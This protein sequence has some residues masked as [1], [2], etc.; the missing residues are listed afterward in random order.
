MDSELAGKHTHT[1]VCVCVCV[2]VC[3]HCKDSIVVLTNDWLLLRD[4]IIYIPHLLL[5]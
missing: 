5:T 1:R 2:C 3:V 4:V